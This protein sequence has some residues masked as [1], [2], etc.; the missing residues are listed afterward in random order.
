MRT[1]LPDRSLTMTI[2]PAK[3]ATAESDLDIVKRHVRSAELRIASRRKLIAFLAARRQLLKQ[4]REPLHLFEVTWQAHVDHL[5][6]VEDGARRRG[7]PCRVSCGMP[8]GSHCDFHTGR[9]GLVP[10]CSSVFRCD[11]SSV[12][13]RERIETPCKFPDKQGIRFALNRKESQYP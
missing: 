11:S 6:H 4:A 10:A 5:V 12:E 2:Q 13:T 1:V 9:L 3:S 8:L 7:P